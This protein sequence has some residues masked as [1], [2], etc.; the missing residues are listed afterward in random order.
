MSRM[1][2]MRVLMVAL[3]AASA[4]HSLGLSRE[5]EKGVRWSGQK[6]GESME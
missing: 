3:A 5:R 1:S 6:K 4:F 2:S